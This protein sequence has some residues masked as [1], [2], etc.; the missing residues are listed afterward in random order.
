MSAAFPLSINSQ[1]TGNSSFLHTTC[2]HYRLNDAHSTLLWR[3]QHLVPR[4]LLRKMGRN[5][6]TRL[7]PSNDLFTA[8]ATCCGVLIIYRSRKISAV[9]SMLLRQNRSTFHR[10]TGSVAR[11]HCVRFIVSKKFV[12]EKIF[13]ATNFRELVI[14]RE[15]RKDFCLAKLSH[16]TVYQKRIIGD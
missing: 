8:S 12:E 5:L 11:R 13:T 7:R 14:D 3:E 9:C 1:H 6:A 10:Y 15:N 4:L 16:Y 2:M